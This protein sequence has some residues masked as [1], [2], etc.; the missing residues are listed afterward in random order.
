MLVYGDRQE[1][2]DPSTRAR[3]INCQL[4]SVEAM[5]AGID[6]HGRLVATL[7]ECGRL[8]QGVVDAGFAEKQCDRRSDAADGLAASL[9]ALGRAVC[10]SWDSGFHE[11]GELPRLAA[12]RDW[13]AEAELRVPEGFAF[14]AV[15]PEAY[16]EAAR[17]LDLIA[18]PRVIG[19][20]SI[21]TAL[22]AVVAAALNASEPITVRPFGDPAAR[23]VAIGAQLERELL[24]GEYHYVIVDEGP[25]Q[26]GSSFAAVADWLRERG[27]PLDRIALL[28]SHAE[29][30]GAAASEALRQWWSQVQRQPADFAAR[31][32]ES[33]E[34]WC[35]DALGDLDETPR[36]ISAGRWRPLLYSDESDWPATITAWE[37]RKYLV[38]AA[39]ERFLVKFAGLGRVGE[40]KLAIARTLHSEGLVPEPVAFVHGFLV[41]RWCDDASPIANCDNPLAELAHYIGTRARLLPA[42]SGSGASIDELLIMAKRNVALEF[43]DEAARILD[44][45]SSR[46]REL[47]RRIVRVRIDGKLERCEWL[48][49]K[50]GALIKTDALD[51]H[52]A[53]DL[54]GAQD[55]AWDV[56]GAL[57]EFDVAQEMDRFIASLEHSADRQVD[58]ELLEFYLIA[59]SAFR[60][61]QF[62]LGETMVSDIGEQQRLRARG[63]RDAARLQ[64]LLPGTLA[65]TR[66]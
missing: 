37:R 20:R 53:H 50:S 19:I 61:G 9:L 22:A 33:I 31:W 34:R 44:R 26:S 16:I 57:A 24:D 55:L 52:Q 38:Q 6:R 54:I 65:P 64:L 62:R 48:R 51:H 23:I 18:P 17:R 41:E 58:R 56:A 2:A 63:N 3:E 36:D 8:L 15:Y 59:Y 28:P 25:G 10:R 5:A 4:D 32:R 14:Y 29:P 40:E 49:T 47:D 30:P 42:T 66:P 60:L 13:P 21:G 45:W 12:C 46:T 35:S 1:R 7:D 39:D 11:L 27:V 43:G